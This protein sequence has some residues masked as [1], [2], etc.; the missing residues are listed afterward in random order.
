MVGDET[1]HEGLDLDNVKSE[2]EQLNRRMLKPVID[3]VCD[4]SIEE[5]AFR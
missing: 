5:E 4:E 3:A 1:T 2:V